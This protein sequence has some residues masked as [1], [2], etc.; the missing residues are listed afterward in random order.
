MMVVTAVQREEVAKY[1]G[2]AYVDRDIPYEL[3]S[4][5]ISEGSPTG[6]LV[7]A[8]IPEDATAAP[9]SPGQEPV[10]ETLGY[11]VDSRYPHKEET[12]KTEQCLKQLP[13]SRTIRRVNIKE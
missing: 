3:S 5:P 4:I 1:P 7:A 12:D 8:G 10:D 2:I 6:P 9:I 13:G 11:F